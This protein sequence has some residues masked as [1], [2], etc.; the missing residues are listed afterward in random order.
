[1]RVD[2]A[3][4]RVSSTYTISEYIICKEGKLPARGKLQR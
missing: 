1:M 3:E 2:T 4:L